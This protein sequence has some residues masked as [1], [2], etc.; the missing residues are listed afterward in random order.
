MHTFLLT[1]AFV[2]PQHTASEH[3]HGTG[4][5]GGERDGGP[6]DP[7]DGGEKEGAGC[8]G[9]KAWMIAE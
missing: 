4:H 3:R 5:G 7:R 9:V 8:E 1:L 2:E 6:M